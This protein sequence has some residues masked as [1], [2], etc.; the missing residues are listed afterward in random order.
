[1]TQDAHNATILADNPF[2]RYSVSVYRKDNCADFLLRAQNTL[3]LDINVLLF[4]GWLAQQKKLFIV[5]PQHSTLITGF[6]KGITERIRHLRIKSKGFNSSE[7]YKAL[8]DLE[9]HAEYHQ[10][11]RL[12]SLK[13]L[14]P[15]VD[16]SI[17]DIIQK[18]IH[19][20][21]QF[22]LGLDEQELNQ[23]GLDEL[24]LGIFEENDNWLQTLIEYLQPVY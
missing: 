13:K 10:Q 21:I 23:R 12:V 14:M 20:Y 5:T 15:S 22:E 6:Q 7:F 18:G 19:H 17:Q 16:L 1:V 4:I 8:L 11:A 9:L 2:W 3:K 24:G